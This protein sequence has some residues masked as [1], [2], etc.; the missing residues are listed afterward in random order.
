MHKCNEVIRFTTT[1]WK[2][3]LTFEPYLVTLT[4]RLGTADCVDLANSK[5]KVL[6]TC[7]FLTNLW[8]AMQVHYACTARVAIHID[9]NLIRNSAKCTALSALNLQGQHSTTTTEV[10]VPSVPWRTSWWSP[11]ECSPQTALWSTLSD[12]GNGVGVREWQESECERGGKG[13]GGGVLTEGR[14]RRKMEE[15]GAYWLREEK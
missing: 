7:E 3:Q 15:G 4:T 14:G 10:T 8:S 9:H 13:G 5:E 11:V 2:V 12:R 6:C 1:S